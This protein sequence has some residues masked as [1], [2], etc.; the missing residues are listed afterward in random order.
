MIYLF[1]ACQP[2]HYMNGPD[3]DPAPQDSEVQDLG[4]EVFDVQ[5]EL[6]E[7]IVTVVRVSWTTSTET[8]GYVDFGETTALGHT[9][10]TTELG[11][12][13]EVLLLGMPA[14]TDVQFVVHATDGTDS[15]QSD[16]LSITTGPLPSG[17]PVLTVTG[18]VGDRWA[19]QAI[20]LQGTTY[21]ITLVDPLGRIVW[22]DFPEPK[23]NLMRALL[24][25]AKDE[26][27]YVWAGDQQHLDEGILVRVSLDGSERTEYAWPFID[28]DA[29]VLPD[30]TVAGIVVTEDPLLG[31]D[32][33]Q[34]DD[35]VE[36]DADGT[37]TSVWSAYDAIDWDELPPQGP[38]NWTHANGLDYVVD[39]DFYLVS[40]KELGSIAKVHRSTGETQWFLNGQLN[41]F[42]YPDG[43]DVVQMQHQMHWL[44]DSILVF[45]NGPESRDYSRIVE[46]ELNEE[47]ME[48]EEVWEYIREPS[49][50]V[51]AK[52][53]VHRFD[54][55]ATQVVWSIQ[56]EIQLVTPDKEVIWQLNT[57]LGQAL[58]FVQVIDD[59]YAR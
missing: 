18:D 25:P 52:G 38:S 15:L 17:M 10:N 51:F 44:G 36:L 26:I 16:D 22:Y 54:D 42:S 11:T 2:T 28:H 45:D 23:G 5:A 43:T 57:D 14:D 3:D 8:T 7:D 56:G 21:V 30:G 9:T 48:A 33:G 39:G 24:S 6:A 55:G 13:H 29:D 35:I 37:L 59:L 32:V 4:F 34:T 41:E 46:I 1:L 53:D 40:L 12:E 27:V 58:T 20:P 49:V 31:G 47:T 50:K 19:Y